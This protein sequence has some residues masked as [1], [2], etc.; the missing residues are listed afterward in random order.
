M[1]KSPSKAKMK[2]VPILVL[3]FFSY[4]LIGQQLSFNNELVDTIFIKAHSGSYRSDNRGTTTGEAEIISL[5]FDTIENH[6]VIERFYRDKY[7]RTFRPDTIKIRKKYFKSKVGKSIDSK[8]IQALLTSLS[9]KK[10]CKELLEQIDTTKL[11][12]FLTERHISKAAKWHGVN[13]HFRRKYSSKKENGEFFK[14]CQSIDT[15]KV[16]LSEQ[17]YKT[18]Y[19]TVNNAW[20]IFNIWISTDSLEHRFEGKYPNPVKQPWYNHSAYSSTLAEIVPNLNINQSLY[21]LLPRGFLLKETITTKALAAD[22]ITWYFRRRD[23]KY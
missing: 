10:S 8:R 11:K 4:A 21:K 15:L 9:T 13:W 23:I 1:Q 19:G 12:S 6:Y 22:F 14:S 16:Y 18:D 7:K 20:S 2:N 3:I 5:I 17:F